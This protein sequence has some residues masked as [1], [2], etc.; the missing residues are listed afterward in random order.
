[1]KLNSQI[2]TVGAWVFLS[3]LLCLTYWQYQKKVK[4][5]TELDK[6]Y[7]AQVTVLK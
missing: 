1:M 6:K 2:F 3:T 4:D 5:Y 7:Q